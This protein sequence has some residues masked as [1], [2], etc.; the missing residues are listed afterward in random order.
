MTAEMGKPVTDGLAEVEKCA[1]DCDVLRRARGGLSW[2]ASRSTI[3][4][5]EGLRHLQSARRGAGG[6]ALELPVLAGLPLRRAGADGGQ[7]RACSSTPATCRAARWRSR[8][9]S[10][11]AG[12]PE[13]LFRTAAGPE[14]A[15]STALI[16]D[17][18]HRRG[19]PH[20]QR[21]RRPQRRRG[22]RRGAEE[23]R[24]RARRRGRLPGA[25]GR[26]RRRARPRSAATA[27]MVNG[28]QS[29][30][31]GK[32]FIVVAR[33]ARGLRG[34]AGRGDARL[35]DGRPARSGAPSSARC[36]ASPRATRST[37]QVE[38]SIASRRAPAARRRDPRPAGRLVSADRARP[39]SRPGQP[40]HD[41]EVFGPVAAIIEAAG[42]ARGD[43]D[44]Q[45]QRVRPRLGRADRAT[46]RAASASPPR[47]SRP[48]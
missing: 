4:G 39:T 10:R 41:E 11:E 43:R 13:D 25:R 19:H 42:R 29:C 8:R 36:T 44:R 6:D 5:A 7:R 15:R 12:F 27:R 14:R 26:R 20:R 47:S 24:A 37:H 46:W 40:A 32:R 28:G 2:R 30:I 18:A 21:R 45:R 38:E 23:V 22:R 17:R 48:A 33:V 9:C 3:E 31:A 16:E 35:R 1:G 34:G